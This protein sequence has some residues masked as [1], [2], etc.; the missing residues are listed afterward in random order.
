MAHNIVDVDTWTASVAVPDDG[1]AANAA[2]VEA[3]MQDLA[4]RTLYLRNR[5]PSAA[6]SYQIVVPAFCTYNEN[7]RFLYDYGGAACP[8]PVHADTTDAGGIMCPLVG[9]PSSGTITSVITRVNGLMT[10][11]VHGGLLGT[12]PTATLLRYLYTT[13]APTNVDVAVDPYATTDLALYEQP[14]PIT[15]AALAE[16]L[17]IYRTYAMVI[18]GENGA[19]KANDKFGVYCFVVT[20]TP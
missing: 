13:G 7:S 14:H 18:T 6:A 17:S 11:G 19:N 9:L 10:A 5:L 8:F 4:D 2:S 1:D 12:A 16:S 20:I 3:G 15:S